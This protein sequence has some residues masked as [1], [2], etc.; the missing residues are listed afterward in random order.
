[1]VRNMLVIISV[2]DYWVG[3]RIFKEQ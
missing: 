2:V 3:N 1:M